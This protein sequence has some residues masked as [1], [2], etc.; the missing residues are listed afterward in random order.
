LEHN[1]EPI[2]DFIDLSEVSGIG[3]DSVFSLVEDPYTEKDA[4][5]H[6]IRVRDLIGAAPERIDIASGIQA[7][8]SLVDSISAADG[9]IRH[10]SIDDLS[11]Y[12]VDG[13]VSNKYLLLP[14]V[15]APKTIKSMSLSPWNPP[16]YHLRNKGHLLYLVIVNLEGEQFHITSHISGFYVNRSSH[17]KFDP[18]PKPGPKKAHSLL[19]LLHQID[20]R[21]SPAFQQLLEHNSKRDPLTLFQLTNTI[22]ANPW[23][24]PADSTSLLEHKPDITRTQEAFLFSGAD[25]NDNLR[26]WNEEFQTTRELPLESVPEK[27]FRERLTSKLFAEFNDA[28]V[29]GAV[30]VARGEIA[31]LNPTEGRDAQIFVHNN[32]F[33]SFG[34]DGVGTFA[35]EGGDEAA[36][37]ATGKDVCGVRAVNQLDI[38]GLFTAATIIVDYL[39]KR[40]VGQSVVPGIFKQREPGDSI[41]YGGVEGKDVIAEKPEFVEPFAALSKAI[42]LKKH[43]VWDKEG[44]RH[45]L[46]ASVDT[47]GLLGTDG[48]K[49]V[50]DLYRLAPLDVTWLEKYWGETPE[51]REGEAKKDYPHRMAVLRP[52]LI[53]SYRLY[54]LIQR[55][56]EGMA[57]KDKKSAETNG[58]APATN[59]HEDTSDS[60]DSEEKKSDSAENEEAKKA[61]EEA[62]R[63]IYSKFSFT[64]NPDV[65]SGQVPRTDE[66]KEQMAKDEADVRAVCEHLTSTIIPRL[67]QQLQEGDVGFPLDGESLTTLLHKRGINMRY[68]GT[69][70]SLSDKDNSRLKAV[71][72]L[73]IQEI[74]SRSF[75]HVAGKYLRQVPHPL[76]SACVSHLLNCLLGSRYNSDPV[77]ETDESLKSLYMD[78]D[79][80]FE[81]LTPE[82][83]QKEVVEEAHKRYRFDL[84]GNLVEHGREMQMLREISLKL[85]LQLVARDYTFEEH[86]GS[87]GVEEHRLAVNGHGSNGSKKKKKTK[88][89]T[90][91][92][93]VEPCPRSAIKQTFHADDIVN[94]VPVVKEASPKVNANL[95]PPPDP[96]ANRPSSPPSPM[97]PSKPAAPP[98][99]KTNVISAKSSSWNRLPYTTKSMASC[100]PKSP[101]CTSPSP[102]STS[103]S[104]KRPQPQTSRVKL[105]SSPNAPWGSTHR[106]LFWR[107]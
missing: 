1:G 11:E 74:V 33:Y 103:R 13:A 86:A 60:S 87:N 43:P 62:R 72:R 51:E 77:P 73:A 26:D 80:E 100:T 4:R 31:P 17:N 16:P 68:L 12:E 94:F 75:K 106:K 59:G 107:I 27:V 84:K 24:V 38:P 71:H 34:A 49:Y 54:K 78:G 41:D 35:T 99:H 48:R 90:S 104:T 39:G 57:A 5:L 63:E 8:A 7:G 88:D 105:S 30:L 45:D 76:T 65:F 98:L 19:T 69:L 96:L 52:E 66:E 28:A 101:A 18:S 10:T 14:N 53:E 58:E 81:S 70:A 21:F 85:G 37:V 22:P 102:T 6:I 61:D 83:L 64:L 23:L 44:K 25:N 92:S 95:I 55:V 47:K 29:R 82:G 97:K 56:D 91:P 50:L 32:V 42:H 93:R 79:Y 20:P 36:R 40:I 46:E 3:P 67:I 2:N 15:S 9:Q 89:S